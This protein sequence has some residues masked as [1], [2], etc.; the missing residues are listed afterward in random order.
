MSDIDDSEEKRAESTRELLEDAAQ[1]AL[2]Y[3]DRL[4]QRPV[5]ASCDATASV[6]MLGGDDP[7]LEGRPAAE[8]LALL[9]EVGRQGTVASA[10]PRY[11]GFV[12]GGAL[13]IALAANWLAGA[14]DQNAFSEMS[15][16]MGAAVERAAL[17]RVSEILDLPRDAQ[18]AFVTGATMANFTALAAARRQVL[19]A[20][21]HDVD[22]DGLT[23]APPITVAVGEGAH[24]T[25]LKAIG[26]LGLG[27]G[28]VVR[29]AA[30]AQGRMRPDALPRLQGPAIVCTQAGNVNTGAIDPIARICTEVRAKDAW[31][32]VDGAFGLW[33]RALS[34][35]D[36]LDI[37]PAR[38]SQAS[39]IAA[40]GLGIE[41]AD[42]WATDAHKWLNVPY[43]CGI[44]LVRNPHALRG[45]MSM[46][47]DY[48]PE[49]AGCEPFEHT[50]EASRRMRALEVL[51]VLETLGKTGVS[52]LIER[53][54]HQARRFAE[55]LS[56]A[57]FEV[58]NEVSLNQ[59]LV[60]FGDDATT[61]KVIRTLQEEGTCWCGGTRWQNRDAMRI[62]LSSW[63]T[64]DADVDRSLDAM[65]RVAKS[66]RDEGTG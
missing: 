12:T 16:P 19:L 15:S 30:D 28:K 1:R 50:P 13:P 18:G 64:R 48:L 29:V 56:A 21:D 23:D 60:S 20:H 6:R 55:G 32:H 42:S 10:G 3:L 14:W 36:T 62:S 53:N 2:A 41:S 24:A 11:F 57:G 35:I 39:R 44:A 27:R 66:V 43:D 8:V 9:D 4:P 40:Q 54:C 34:S 38:K 45:A 31:V 65:L 7:S 49:A 47:A 17:S 26:L 5:L 46:Q 33:V 61:R 25:V 58:L 51:A 63:A 52:A 59:V 22:R 37:D